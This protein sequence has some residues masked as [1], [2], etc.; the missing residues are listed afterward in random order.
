MKEN[1][2]L[3]ILNQAAAA[4]QDHLTVVNKRLPGSVQSHSYRADFAGAMKGKRT[5]AT[6]Q[7][8]ADSELARA[9]IE[10]NEKADAIS[11]NLGNLQR[12]RSWL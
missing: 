6:L 9:K 12:K 7:D 5:I 1:R 3:E 2:R 8:A 10:I 4:L 11:Y